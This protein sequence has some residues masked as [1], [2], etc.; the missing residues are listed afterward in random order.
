MSQ[1]NIPPITPSITLT[2][3]EAVNLLIASVAMEELGL[4]HVLNAEGEK[5]QY[6]LGTLTDQPLSEPSS[7]EEV[8]AIN[9]SVKDLIDTAGINQMMLD[10]KLKDI[11]RI[12]TIRG[13]TGA[14]GAT[15]A[16][17]SF[18]GATGPAGPTGATGPVGL[19]GLAGIVGASGTE[20]ITGA[21]GT[22]GA[23]GV[24][25]PTGLAGPAGAN[26]AGM[27]GQL[28]YNPLDASNYPLYQVVQYGGNLYSVVNVPPVGTPG[29]S[30]DYLL[31][32][33]VG[34]TG[35]AGITGSVGETGMTG[36]IAGITGVAGN[37]GVK[38][39]TAPGMTGQVP[40]DIND[41]GTYVAGQVVTYEGATY[42]VRQTPPTGLPG[43]SA[44]YALLAAEGAI[45]PTGARGLTGGIGA[46]GPLGPTGATGLTGA[47]GT[48][49]A[50]G[51][52][53]TKTFFF[54]QRLDGL[55]T[56]PILGTAK[57]PFN[58]N[59]RIGTG[60]TLTSNSERI[61]FS[62]AGDYFVDYRVE[63]ANTIVTNLVVTSTL[64]LNG[65]AV[66]GGSASSLLSTHLEAQTIM[67]ISAGQYLEL[68]M[69]A[70]LGLI[71]FQAPG[72]TIS[73]IYL[74]T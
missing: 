70:L 34:D 65:S 39:A 45:G 42:V 62:V 30:P 11:M 20:G 14:V 36:T 73:I 46:T 74:G 38:G 23:A 63:L 8:L 55:A 37:T 7:L 54:G 44:N 2:R 43:Q 16:T 72:I 67:Q 24:T 40:F 49:G 26:G 35:E 12:P 10:S 50:L 53:T 61:N 56:L 48:R 60:I 15:G 6:V 13:V 27:N 1:A 58:V 51:P 9:D 4:S 28:L 29:L 18:E 17:G 57:V 3:D 19:A 47:I 69:Y 64:L 66:S 52:D 22:I 5:I 31:L 71:P 32:A 21:G 59:Q 41:I 33:A 25:G 68:Q